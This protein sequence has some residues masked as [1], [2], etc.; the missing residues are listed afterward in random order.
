[1]LNPNRNCIIKRITL[2]CCRA[3]INLKHRQLVR[4]GSIYSR[5]ALSLLIEKAQIS[6]DRTKGD[7]YQSIA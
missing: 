4:T 6:I 5:F 1:M 3:S 7:L 2:G